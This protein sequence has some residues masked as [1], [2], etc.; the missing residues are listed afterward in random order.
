[1][2]VSAK[3]AKHA[4][5]RN[6]FKRQLRAIFAGLN[7]RIEKGEDIAIIA[8]KEAIGAPFAELETAVYKVLMKAGSLS[9]TPDAGP[10]P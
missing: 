10:R 8:K 4:V 5:D 2:V 9:R 1:L 7:G 6:R 3:V